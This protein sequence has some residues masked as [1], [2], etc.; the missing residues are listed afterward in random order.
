MVKRKK[1]KMELLFIQNAFLA[2]KEYFAELVIQDSLNKIILIQIAFL[3][4][5]NHT[6]QNTLAEQ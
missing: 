4:K 5:I 6:F 3:A 2:T 1:V